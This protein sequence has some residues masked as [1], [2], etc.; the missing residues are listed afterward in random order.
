M[1]P[2]FPK[3][4]EILNASNEDK[5]SSLVCNMCAN[6]CKDKNRKTVRHVAKYM[7]NQ[8]HCEWKWRVEVKVNGKRQYSKDFIQGR[9]E[10]AYMF[11]V[12]S[13]QEKIL[14]RFEEHVK[15]ILSKK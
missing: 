11:S 2:L 8:M 14:D 5:P 12:S 3:L 9:V 1:L 13:D 15:D 7:S 4:G 10:I 6:A